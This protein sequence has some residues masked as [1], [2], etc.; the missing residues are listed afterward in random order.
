[1]NLDSRRIRDDCGRLVELLRALTAAHA[2]VLGVIRRKTEAMRRADLPTMAQ[3]SEEQAAAL[4]RIDELERE[5]E[6]LTAELASGLAVRGPRTRR[7]RVSE[8]ALLLT[9]EDAAVL[10]READR[11]RQTV[12]AVGRAN[13]V[14]ETIA[15]YVVGHIRHV[16]TSLGA[17][18]AESAGYSE[19]GRR[20]PASGAQIIETTG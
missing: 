16:F 13:H 14:A 3:C 4:R 20:V 7:L 19:G 17:E 15:R 12:T 8:L 5:R 2:E 11:L 10:R 1:M 9:D 18:E 6:R